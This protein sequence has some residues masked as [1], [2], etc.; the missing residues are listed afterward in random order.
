MWHIETDFF[1]LAIF[2][3]MLIKEKTKQQLGQ[4]VEGQAFYMVL[5]ISIINVCIDIVSS[6]AMNHMPGWWFYELTMT[7]YVATMPLL[8][9][10]WMAYS[11]VLIHKDFQRK[12][13]RRNIF[14]MM[15]PYMVYIALACTNPVTGLFFS[16][17]PE[18][19]YSRG[20]LFMSVGVGYIMAYSAAGLLMVIWNRKKLVPKINAV[21]LSLFLGLRH[22]LSGYS[23]QIR[24]GL[25]SM[26]AMLRSMSGVI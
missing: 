26:Q 16:L 1:A 9:A 11:Y 19:D 12:Q 17:S 4:D 15:I 5:L 13:L 18:M 6:Y 2:L 14:C 7:I 23:W 21:L 25:S 20:P 10:V 3:V 8:A 24:D 22:V